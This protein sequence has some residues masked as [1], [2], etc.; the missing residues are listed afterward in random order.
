MAWNKLSNDFTASVS[1]SSLETVSGDGQIDIK[2]LSSTDISGLALGAG[3]AL[4]Q[5]AGAA[6]LVLNESNNNI[7]A[8]ISADSGQLIKTKDLTL[9]P[10]I[11]LILI[12]WPV[13]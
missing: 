2:A 13:R 7:T 11:I 9:K 12:P 10:G 8:K 4:N 6:S 1:N 3:I 5:F